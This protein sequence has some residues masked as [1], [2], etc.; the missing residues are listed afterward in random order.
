MQLDVTTQSSWS[1]HFP[2]SAASLKILCGE[3]ALAIYVVSSLPASLC[4]KLTS[5]GDGRLL[6]RHLTRNG[7]RASPLLL[8]PLCPIPRPTSSTDRSSSADGS[9][10]SVSSPLFSQ[11]KKGRVWHAQ[12]PQ[13]TRGGR[14]PRG[15]PRPIAWGYSAAVPPEGFRRLAVEGWLCSSAHTDTEVTVAARAEGLSAFLAKRA[16]GVLSGC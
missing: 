1:A 14:N 3:P 6:C 7:L 10:W 13:G 12:T 15:F 2:Q 4:R 8:R 9:A 5:S 11:L 16:I